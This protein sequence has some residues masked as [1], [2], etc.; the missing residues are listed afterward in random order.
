MNTPLAYSIVPIAPSNRTSDS[1]SMRRASADVDMGGYAGMRGC[2]DA[3]LRNCRVIPSERSES[4]DLHLR[5]ASIDWSGYGSSSLR[6]RTHG[7]ILGLWVVHDHR[8]R[9]LLGDE[10]ERRRQLHPERLFRR[11]QLEEL[12]VILEIRA[13]AVA[14][15]VALPTTARNAELAP[16]AAM[17]PFSDRFRAL[18]REP[19]L[20]ERFAVLTSRLLP[21]KA[22]CRLVAHRDDLECHD[23]DVATGRRPEVVRDAQPLA[24]F[25]SRE[26]EPRLL[27]ERAITPV[28]LRLVDHELVADALRREVAVHC[29]RMQPAF[30]LRLALE[31]RQRRLELLADHALVLGA[32]AATTPLQAIQ[33]VEVEQVEHFVERDVFQHARAEE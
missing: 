29:F 22:A 21:L 31:S 20:V 12:R 8:G 10:L 19:V 1:G 2:G 9:A 18:D 13:R 15:R 30:C 32:R 33:L 14:P 23:I 17:Q 16:D 3:G 28:R 6:C 5:N 25:L 7:V 27:D 4:R 24:S 26:V 11:Q